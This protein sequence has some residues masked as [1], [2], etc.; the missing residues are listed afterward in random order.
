M[1]YLLRR[2]L[3]LLA[4]KRRQFP[5]RMCYAMTVNKSQGQ[6]LKKVFSHGQ[7][8]VT[9]SRV[10]SP[11]GL[12]VLYTSKQKQDKYVTNI[13]YREV[14]NGLPTNTKNDKFGRE[15]S[16]QLISLPK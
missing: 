12:K 4:V 2:V 1:C 9:L 11:S 13:V 16:R 10:T 6:T 3:T 5:V 14:F 8:Y 7:L 15:N